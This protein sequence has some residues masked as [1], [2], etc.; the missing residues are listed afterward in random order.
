MHINFIFLVHF[1][2]VI[3]LEN[4]FITFYNIIHKIVFYYVTQ[5]FDK[6]DFSTS[7]NTYI[8][9]ISYLLLT[10]SYCDWTII[11]NRMI[12]GGRKIFQFRH[13]FL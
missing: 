8:E 13:V 10:L 11:F 9:A 4:H 1:L 3:L 2:I 12:I 6:F 7:N 5:Y